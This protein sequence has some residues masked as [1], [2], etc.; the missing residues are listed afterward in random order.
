MLFNSAVALF[1]CLDVSPSGAKG[2]ILSG[3]KIHFDVPTEPTP[4]LKWREMDKNQHWISSHT[5]MLFWK[6]WFSAL[7]YSFQELPCSS[8]SPIVKVAFKIFW[9]C[10]LNVLEH[11]GYQS[12]N[13]DVS[14]IFHVDIIIH[15]HKEISTPSLL[16][17]SSPINSLPELN[18]KCAPVA[19]LNYSTTER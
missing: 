14:V 5:Q 11:C 12:P 19:E 10:H 1:S 16:S 9:L 18:V 15:V 2:F 17:K 8:N 7:L 4:S 6:Y 13:C 3:G